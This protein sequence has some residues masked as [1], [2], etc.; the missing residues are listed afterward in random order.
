[1]LPVAAQWNVF[2]ARR[3]SVFG[4]GGLFL[5]RGFYD[6]CGPG[7]GVCDT[8]SDFGV[9]PTFALGVRVRLAPN[10]ALLARL[11]YPTSTVGV[12]FL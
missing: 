6:G 11:G 12:S 4:E 9:L 5:Y 10:V 2:F 1:M 7:N 8:P 3:V